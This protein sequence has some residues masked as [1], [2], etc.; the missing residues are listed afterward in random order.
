MLNAT[1]ITTADPIPIVLHFFVMA[2]PSSLDVIAAYRVG[3]AMPPDREEQHEQAAHGFLHG[4]ELFRVPTSMMGLAHG[5]P[6][7]PLSYG[8]RPAHQ[9]SRISFIPSS[10]L[11]S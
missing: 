7:V 4:L 6:Q 9:M 1:A 11:S 5:R 2:C 3:G 10:F 8:A